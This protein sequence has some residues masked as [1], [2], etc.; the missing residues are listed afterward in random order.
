M[1]TFMADSVCRIANLVQRG[2][3]DRR[4]LTLSFLYI[5]MLM[6]LSPLFFCWGFQRLTLLSL[7]ST[8]PF[9]SPIFVM[10]LF[11]NLLLILLIYT[12]YLYP[13]EEDELIIRSVQKC[14]RFQWK[15]PVR[16]KSFNLKYL[17]SNKTVYWIKINSHFKKFQETQQNLLHSQLHF[18]KHFNYSTGIFLSVGI[19]KFSLPS[20]SKVLYKP[21]FL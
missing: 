13:S 21:V 1:F 16:S 19:K 17:G 3:S 2:L 20:K 4:L 6:R 10:E 14:L 18:K 7:C 8:S 11:Q 15:T 9:L 12:H 5:H